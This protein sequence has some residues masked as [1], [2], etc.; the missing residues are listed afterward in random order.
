MMEGERWYLFGFDFD[1]D[2]FAVV[3]RPGAL[4]VEGVGGHTLI[5]PLSFL[6]KL[7]QLVADGPPFVECWQIVSATKKKVG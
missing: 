2:I 1:V 3:S 6:A 7:R 4:V 5:K